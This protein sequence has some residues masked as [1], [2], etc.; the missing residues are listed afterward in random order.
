M[1]LFRITSKELAGAVDLEGLRAVIR[2]TS[3]RD[4]LDHEP[5][6]VTIDGEE[7]LVRLGIIEEAILIHRGWVTPSRPRRRMR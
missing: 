7:R 4:L 5:Q 2:S 3:S 1:E 6:L